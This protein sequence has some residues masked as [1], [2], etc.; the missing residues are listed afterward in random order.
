MS[1][2]PL[3]DFGE[4]KP[5]SW[6]HFNAEGDVEFKAILYIP[7]KAAHD[8]Y[9]NYYSNKAPLKLYVRRVFISDEFEDLLPKYL[10]FLKVRGGDMER[11]EEEGGDG[12][13]GR[14]RGRVQVQG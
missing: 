13:C 10:N 8:M 1:F 9:D 7:P 14:G 6:T 4:D 2:L 3:Q 11:Q 5:V 12:R